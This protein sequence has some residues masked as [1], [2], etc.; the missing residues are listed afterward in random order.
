MNQEELQMARIERDAGVVRYASVGAGQPLVL[1]HGF[2]DALESWL[3]LGYAA[4]LAGA[5]HRLILIDQRGHGASSKPQDPQA[6]DVG[7]R[8]GDVVAVLDALGVER[9]DLMGYSMG[10]RLALEVARLHA[11]RVGRLIVGG[12]H[13][14]AQSMAFY[15]EAVA[16][17]LE[18]WL[19]I[20]ARLGG[21]RLPA[22]F[23]ERLAVNDAA[24]LRTA[25]A[26]DRPDVSGELAAFARPA[27]FWVGGDDALRGE[28]ARA[29]QLLP[30]G[31]HFEVPGANH[32]TALLDADS[33]VPRVLEFLGR[34]AA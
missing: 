15:R 17:G 22:G 9:A 5:G 6:Y 33:V 29:A 30:Q 32:L 2:S 27:L 14:F 28:V 18:R 12:A 8:A 3:E 4:P 24:A 31:E 16:Q 20:V 13:P 1:L 19:A 10:G 11:E 26:A 23:V 34:T 21:S 7:R 25:M